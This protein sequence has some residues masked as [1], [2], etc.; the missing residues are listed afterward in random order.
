MAWLL[1]DSIDERKK[2]RGS[3]FFKRL[4]GFTLSFHDPLNK[5]FQVTVV[6][7][8]GLDLLFLSVCATRLGNDVEGS[9][10]GASY[11]TT[12]DVFRMMGVKSKY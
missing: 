12:L 8:G 7:K 2:C 6:H 9:V 10:I 11:H 3:V 1:R 5:G 4:G